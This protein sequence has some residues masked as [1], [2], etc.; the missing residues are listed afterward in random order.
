MTKKTRGRIDA[1]LKPQIAL[2]A[3]RE[4]ATVVDLAAALRGPS[5]PDL[6]SPIGIRKPHAFRRLDGGAS[7]VDWLDGSVQAGRPYG[8]G[9]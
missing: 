6:E 2:K 7:G 4:Q 3:V 8:L 5:Q 1:G 9:L